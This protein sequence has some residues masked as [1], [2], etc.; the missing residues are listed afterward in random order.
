MNWTLKL[1][2]IIATTGRKHRNKSTHQSSYSHLF[3]ITQKT[4]SNKFMSN[5]ER[6]YQ[7][8]EETFNKLE[9]R[10]TRHG[11]KY[12]SNSYLI[13]VCYQN[14]QK[15]KQAQGK[16]QRYFPKIQKINR[17]IIWCSTS[18]V[19]RKKYIENFTMRY[20]AHTVIPPHHVYYQKDSR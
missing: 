3:N 18:Q 12:F 4:T 7:V 13:R 15:L 14:I 8:E 11:K 20:K 16:T 17:Y 6:L 5:Q 10:P 9:K 2:L 1:D 19:I